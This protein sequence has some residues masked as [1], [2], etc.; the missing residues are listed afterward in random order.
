MIDR[1]LDITGLPKVLYI[2][3]S[4]G[5]TS[6]FTMMSE[7]PEYNEKIISFV[8]LA[9]AVYVDNMKNMATMFLKTI[10]LP[11]S[12]LNILIVMKTRHGITNDY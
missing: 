4:M 12:F 7:R 8:A 2:G 6:F 1:V 11:V 3:Y 9:P 10:D 5:T